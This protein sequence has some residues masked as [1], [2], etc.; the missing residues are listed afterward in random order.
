MKLLRVRIFGFFIVL[1]GI[2]PLQGMYL[3]RL[4]ATRPVIVPTAQP[5][6][7]QQIEVNMPTQNQLLQRGKIG[8]NLFSASAA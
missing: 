5:M 8:L 6:Q 1:S 4:K 2:L 3:R 7:P